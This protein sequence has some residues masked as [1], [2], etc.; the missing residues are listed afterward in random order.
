MIVK[1]SI[2]QMDRAGLDALILTAPHDI[3]Y[4]TG[5][6]SRRVYRSGRVGGAEAVVN[7]SDRKS[8]V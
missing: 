8:V 2:A 1:K 7:K 3:F 5:H 6:C 4:A